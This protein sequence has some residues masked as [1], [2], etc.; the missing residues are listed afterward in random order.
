[1]ILTCLSLPLK[2]TG[3]PDP[4]Y[5][6]HIAARNLNEVSE[7]QKLAKLL[8]KDALSPGEIKGRGSE[9]T[10]RERQPLSGESGHVK[11]AP[12]AHGPEGSASA[13]AL[14]GAALDGEPKVRPVSVFTECCC[15]PKSL[16]SEEAQR[17]QITKVR[18]TRGSHDLS[19]HAGFLKAKREILQH[20]KNGE[21]SFLGFSSMQG[22]V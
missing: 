5:V 3:Q 10:A 19:T 21:N 2:Q 1:M 11:V 17:K 20:I 8:S 9:D 18:F 12:N 7:S 6:E 22:L 14:A 4:E 15:G 13:Q 16:L